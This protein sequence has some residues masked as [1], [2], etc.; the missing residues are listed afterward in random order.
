M[1]KDLYEVY[2]ITEAPVPFFVNAAKVYRFK[3]KNS[4]IKD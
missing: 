4:E 2:T 1:K 3:A